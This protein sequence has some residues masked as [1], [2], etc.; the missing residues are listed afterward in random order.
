MSCR[1]PV[2]ENTVRHPPISS[3]PIQIS[4]RGTVTY[5]K[6]TTVAEVVTLMRRHTLADVADRVAMCSCGRWFKEPGQFSAHL[7]DEV[8]E[9]LTTPHPRGPAVTDELL[10]E[11]AA[12]H[13]S[14][15]EGDKMRKIAEFL[16]VSPS[17]AG[18]YVSRARKSGLLEPRES[19]AA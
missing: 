2:R 11:V 14:A 10:A 3:E 17:S 1:G 8:Q 5:R 16:G 6:N 4:D 12:I 19:A 18:T 9:Q 15:P 7:I 13:R